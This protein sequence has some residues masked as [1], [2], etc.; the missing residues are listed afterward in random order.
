MNKPLKSSTKNYAQKITQQKRKALLQEVSNVIKQHSSFDN[1]YF[2][3]SPT[4][5][6]LRR[7]YE[8]QNSTQIDFM[9]DGHLYTY[10]CEPECSCK[11]IRYYH[12]FLIDEKPV[13]DGKKVTVR[14]FKKVQE[15]LLNAINAYDEKQAK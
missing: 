4:L 13:F 5:A 2:K 9:Y 8:E 12:K 15:E 7:Q 14:Q 3:D 10:W 11:Y 1:V 6:R